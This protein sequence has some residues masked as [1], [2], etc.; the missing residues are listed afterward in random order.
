M[1]TSNIKISMDLELKKEFEE[2]CDDVGM[3]M[4]TAFNIYAKKVVN[5]WQIPFKIGYE[6]PNGENRKA[7]K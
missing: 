5:E 1:A 2:F 6:I 7:M 4:N 3:D